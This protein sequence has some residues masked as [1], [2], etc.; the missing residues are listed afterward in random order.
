[1]RDRLQELI[2]EYGQEVTG[3]TQKHMNDWVEAVEESLQ[4]FSVQVESLE[5]ALSDFTPKPSER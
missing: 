1:M 5:G 4:K 3:Q 2:Q